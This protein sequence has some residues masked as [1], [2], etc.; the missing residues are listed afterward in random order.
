[1]ITNQLEWLDNPKTMNNS[2]NF[3]EVKIKIY[4]LHNYGYVT[5]K[6]MKNES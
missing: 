2:W 4:L 5:I 6:S 3:K 1:M